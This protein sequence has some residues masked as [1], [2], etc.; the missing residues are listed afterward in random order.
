[1]FWCPI[2]TLFNTAISFLTY[3]A[4]PSASTSKRNPKVQQDPHHMLSSCH[5]PLVDHLGCIVSSSFYVY[6]F[7]DH[8]I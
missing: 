5:E 6:A 7:F 1:M 4:I 2:E 3:A 8:R